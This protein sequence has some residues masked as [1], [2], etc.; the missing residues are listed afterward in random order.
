MNRNCDSISPASRNSSAGA[1]PIIGRRCARSCTSS[2]G[3]YVRA[4]VSLGKY[5]FPDGLPP[6]TRMVARNFRPQALRD[7]CDACVSRVTRGETHASER[8]AM[9]GQAGLA[10]SRDC[11]AQW[12][13]RAC[14]KRLTRLDHGENHDGD[15]EQRRQFVEAAQPLGAARVALRGGNHA[16][17]YSS[18]AW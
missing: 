12:S 7:G 6:H 16:S 2:G 8:L 17:V 9:D 10:R 5:I 15:Q 3:V 13:P 4:L 14:A 18:S 11:A 1:G